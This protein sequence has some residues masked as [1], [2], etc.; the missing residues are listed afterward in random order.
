MSSSKISRPHENLSLTE[1]VS[2]SIRRNY[3]VY[4]ALRIK[5]A[6]YHKIASQIA[7]RVQELIGKKPKVA[8][9]VVAVKRFSDGMAE[10]RASMLEGILEDAQVGLTSGVVELSL[11]ARD[12]PPTKVLEEVL[13]ITP[14]LSTMPEIVQLPAVVK[15]VA[16]REDGMMIEKELG[17][18]FEAKLEEG[19]ARITVRISRRAE[20]VVGLATF[21]AEL[22]YLNGVVVQSAYIGRP[23]IMLIVEDR[24]GPLGYEVLSKKTRQRPRSL[25]LEAG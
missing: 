6:N 7:P 12:I 20:K 15:V 25:H 23:D 1:A 21:I 22:L 4:E 10:K 19:M 3:I 24:F 2:I 14:R 11:R 8:T 13:K 17:D 5:V 9:L 18:R 16:Q